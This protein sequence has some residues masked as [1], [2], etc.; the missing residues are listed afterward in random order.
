[1]PHVPVGIAVRRG[2]LPGYYRIQPVKQE[3][4]ERAD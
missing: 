2:R 1:M 3:P 4:R